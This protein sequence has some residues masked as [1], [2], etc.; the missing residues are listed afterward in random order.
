MS[1]TG[2]ALY[3]AARDDG[4]VVQTEAGQAGR[5][6]RAITD[7]WT[8]YAARL[9]L[10]TLRTTLTR[11]GNRKQPVEICMART[12]RVIR[13]RHIGTASPP[14]STPPFDDSIRRSDWR[15][16]VAGSGERREQ[17]RP[18]TRPR[19]TRLRLAARFNVVGPPD[20]PFI[21]RA[22]DIFD[23]CRLG[24]SSVSFFRLRIFAF[25]RN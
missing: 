15:P 24:F 23:H 13:D 2:W 4:D 17:T 16:E 8:Q 21:C 7:A 18:A 14:D 20:C 22:H 6:R 19:A 11:A 10:D 1:L 5:L 9:G 25:L 3:V 12:T